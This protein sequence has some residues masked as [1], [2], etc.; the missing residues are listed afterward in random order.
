MRV[1]QPLLFAGQSFARLAGDRLL[2]LG[3]PFFILGH[4]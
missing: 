3:R 1:A 4:Q 2:P